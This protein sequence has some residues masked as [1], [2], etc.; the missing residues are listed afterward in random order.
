M[1]LSIAGGVDPALALDLVEGWFG[2]LRPRPSMPPPP[3]PRSPQRGVYHRA[4][5]RAQATVIAAVPTGGL[6][7]PDRRRLELAAA[8]LGGP[9]GR[10]FLSLRERRGLGYDTWADHRV[11]TDG[12]L[13]TAGVSCAPDRVDEARHS[14]VA[15][16]ALIA[17]EGPTTEELQRVCN[18]LGGELASSLQ[19]ASTRAAFLAGATLF[20][21]PRTVQ[22]IA[23]ERAQVTSEGVRSAL[24]RVRLTQPVVLCVAPPP[25]A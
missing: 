2:D 1:V 19:R 10:L 11:G 16:L 21:R 5:G 20:D 15:E 6:H 14:L 18:L 22:A 12:G 4:A 24:A 7:D 17:Q 13:L 9:G 8:V 23:T 25:R 3:A